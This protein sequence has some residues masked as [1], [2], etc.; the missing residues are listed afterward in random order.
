LAAFSDGTLRVTASNGDKAILLREAMR[1]YLGR[2]GFSEF[3]RAVL[4]GV[5][6]PVTRYRSMDGILGFQFRINDVKRYAPARPKP[7]VPSGLLTH[8]MAAAA[9]KT[10]TEVVRNLVAQGL[11]HRHGSLPRGIQLLRARDVEKFASRY[12]TVKAIA[13]RIEVGSR[14]VAETLK[15]NGAEVLVIPLPGKG[16]KLFVRRS[17]RS[18]LAIRILRQKKRSENASLYHPAPGVENGNATD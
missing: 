2:K 17:P 7:P 18:E 11:L 10:N 16:N 5:L 3:I 9:L 6:Q 8:S 15:Q 4:S 13:E 14:T 12:V 1:G